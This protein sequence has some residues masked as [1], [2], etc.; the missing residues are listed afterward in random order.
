MDCVIQNNVLCKYHDSAHNAYWQVRHARIPKH[1]T[2]I[3]EAVFKDYYQ[4][5]TVEIPE[6]VT[7]IGR[8]AFYNSGLKSV[9]IPEG[10]ME[11]GQGTFCFCEDLQS[12]TI[13]GSVTQIGE[14]AFNGCYS[15][16]SVTIPEGVTEI[17]LRA[18]SHCT[19]LK[20][21]TIP[22]GV[23][24]IGQEAF[25]HCESL[26]SVT[27]PERVTRIG[28]SAFWNCTGLQSVTIQGSVTEIDQNV[29]W[30]CTGLQSVTIQSEV[31]AIYGVLWKGSNPVVIA[32]HVSIS[33]FDALDKPN[34]CAGFAKLYWDR[35]PLSEEIRTGYLAYIKSYRKSLYA[36]AMEYLPLLRLMTAEKMIPQEEFE[37]LFGEALQKGDAEL[38]VL[39]L[40]YRHKNFKPVDLEREFELEAL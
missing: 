32:P 21:V 9:T 29:F 8:C 40:E 12:V 35:V 23:T 2:E 18:F 26:K 25:S 14:Q 11:I 24:Q 1:V 22:E 5:E 31:G 7:K 15:L 16:K 10:V 38:T 30:N 27:I 4:L 33:S 3:G 20:S 13:P 6:S 17:A 19:S 39:L 37:E 36:R 28:V 34:A